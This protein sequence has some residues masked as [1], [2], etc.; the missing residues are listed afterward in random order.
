MSRKPHKPQSR[1]LNSQAEFEEFVNYLR[2]P[3]RIFWTNFVSGILRGLGIIV[4]MSIVF[5]LVLW[6]IA[7][8]VDFPLIGE[9]VEQAQSKLQEYA[10]QTNYTDNFERIEKI[11]EEKL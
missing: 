1:P 5:A 10:E 9:Y 2:S 3:W 8:F 7:I 11:L 4:G 6:L